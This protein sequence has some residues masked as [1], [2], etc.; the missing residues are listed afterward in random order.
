MKFVARF[1]SLAVL[2][3]AAIFIASCGGDDTDPKSEEETQ[4]ELLSKTW[5]LTD[6]E[7]DNTPRFADF[8]GMK[9]T[10]SGAFTSG[11]IYNF[12]ITGTTP[13]PSPWPSDGTWK[14]GADVKTQMIRNPG[15]GANAENLEMTYELSGNTLKISFR[16]ED[17]D[18]DGGRVASVDG[19][20]D[21]T[22]T[23]N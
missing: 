5:T 14:F 2:A 20:W 11:G 23:S 7:L 12:D 18:F 22:F 8:P 4:L 19:E 16:C 17:C 1:L 9:L 13:D 3:G 21:F 6:A 10:L 15:S